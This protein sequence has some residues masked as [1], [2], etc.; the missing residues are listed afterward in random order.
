MHNRKAFIKMSPSPTGVMS[1]S[2]SDDDDDRP[3]RRTKKIDLSKIMWS[4][5][6]KGAKPGFNR[7]GLS[8]GVLSTSIKKFKEVII[9]LFSKKM[10]SLSNYTSPLTEA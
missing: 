4:G 2:S 9:L 10:I 7:G 3:A 6:P 5:A 8:L 1:M